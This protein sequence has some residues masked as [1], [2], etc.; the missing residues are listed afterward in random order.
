MAQRLIPGAMAVC[1]VTA[2]LA[3]NAQGMT[4]PTRPP[5]APLPPGQ[6]DSTE[7]PNSQLQS[8]LISPTRKLAVINGQ[9]IALG[10]RFGEAQLVSI[11]ESSVVLK[12]GEELETLRL[13]PGLEK[14]RTKAVD[15]R[16]PQKGKDR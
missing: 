5:S 15:A 7:G 12:R 10:G 6:N 13:L 3:A 8:V 14:T 4:D 2:C 9:T 16:R 1:M 11:S